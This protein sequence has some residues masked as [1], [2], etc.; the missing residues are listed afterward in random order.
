MTHS[1]VYKRI[2]RCLL[3]LVFG[4]ASW[5]SVSAE[6]WGSVTIAREQIAPADKKKF[7][8]IGE[9]TFEGGF[10][11]FAV[12]AARGVRAG[13]T[14]CVTAAIHG[15]EVN[16]VEIA[17]RVFAETQTKELSGMLVVLPAVNASGF[18]TANRYL[19]DRRDLNRSF[20]G[21]PNGSV[22]AILADAVF[23][24]VITG[25]SYLI[26]LHTASNVR[27]NLAQIRVDVAEPR[28]LELAKQFGVGII[29]AGAGPTGSLR[30]E[31]MKIGI[32]AIIYEAGPPY[33]FVEPEIARGVEGIRN[34]MSRL[35]MISSPPSAG[36]AQM[37][38]T[39]HWVR[40][41]RGQGGIYRPLVKLGD[42]VDA[43]QM[44]A[45]VTDPVT[46]QINEIRAKKGGVVVGMALP[47]VVLSGYGIVHVGT[48]SP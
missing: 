10:I 4:A 23:R 19:P 1:P 12:F 34:V 16:S 11:D 21:S 9:R 25:C 33:V 28:A 42:S 27:T 40:V 41:P 45:T 47:Q 7:T 24:G 2:S 29:V 5:Q 39:S 46:D 31:A 30:R 43:G 8:F 32:P 13:P 3:F 35:R 36:H 44:L 48:V 17:R 15:D 38:G 22:A 26:D 18:R 20:P 37:L 14:L 6:E